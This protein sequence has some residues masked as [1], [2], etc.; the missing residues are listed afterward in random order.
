MP[1]LYNPI[2]R[3]WSIPIEPIEIKD[4]ISIDVHLT[5]FEQTTYDF[6][7]NVKG[8]WAWIK[9]SSKV[10]D[11]KVVHYDRFSLSE[12]H[13]LIMFKLVLPCSEP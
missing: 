3:R 5:C 10:I 9:S 6:F 1:R 2:D 7:D 8:R 13:Q 4:W 12:R 11:R